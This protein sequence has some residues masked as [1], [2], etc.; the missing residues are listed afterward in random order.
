M[1]APVPIWKGLAAGALAEQVSSGEFKLA[2]RI[3]YK[4]IFCGRYE[5]CTNFAN[6]HPRASLWSITV[7]GLGSGIFIVDDSTAVRDPR[8]G[9]TAMVTINYTYLASVPPPEFACTPFEI[10]PPCERNGFFAELTQQ[11]LQQAKTQYNSATARGQTTLTNAIAAGVNSTTITS[12]INKWLKGEE[13]Y[14]QAGFK[15][16]YTQYAY[17][18]GG[19]VS[20]GGVI[21]S[22]FGRVP[23]GFMGNVPGGLSWLRQADELS[24]NNGLWKLTQTWIGAPGGWWDT[25]L[26]PAG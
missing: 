12:L 7:A 18:L 5:D 26:Y 3:T 4:Q 15:V 22:P 13:T 10:N 21:Q 23:A 6:L 19:A 8:K 25:D 17:T 1:P 16:V 11:D 20:G 24:W 14:Y 2:E 9:N